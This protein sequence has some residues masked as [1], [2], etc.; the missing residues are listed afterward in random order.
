MTQEQILEELKGIQNKV[1]ELITA[2]TPSEQPKTYMHDKICADIHVLEDGFEIDNRKNIAV[3]SF[4]DPEDKRM[5][6]HQSEYEMYIRDAEKII[7]NMNFVSIFD[8]KLEAGCI[9]GQ[10]VVTVKTKENRDYKEIVEN[11]VY[12]LSKNLRV[13][14][15]EITEELNLNEVFLEYEQSSVVSEEPTEFKIQG[16]QEPKASN[17]GELGSAVFKHNKTHPRVYSQ[18][19]K[20]VLSIADIFGEVN[21]FLVVYEDSKMLFDAVSNKVIPFEDIKRTLVNEDA[22]VYHQNQSDNIH[23]YEIGKVFNKVYCFNEDFVVVIPEKVQARDCYGD[24]F[25][26]FDELDEQFVSEEASYNYRYIF[27]T[28]D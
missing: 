14:T 13:T 9:E 22:V 7:F 15:D 24:I 26:Q 27:Y 4:Y 28:E 20:E 25:V 18:G 23:L 5:Y 1:N 16:Y 12:G 19:I 8:M 6:Y 11:L 21:D 10:Y 3:M 2:L 17:M